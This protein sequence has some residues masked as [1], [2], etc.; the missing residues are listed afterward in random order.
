MKWTW[1]LTTIGKIY[2]VAFLISHT[3]NVPEESAK[4][5][6]PDESNSW[7]VE[8]AVANAIPKSQFQAS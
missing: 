2:D 3:Q 5:Q 6:F 7:Q 4:W 8:K 1:T